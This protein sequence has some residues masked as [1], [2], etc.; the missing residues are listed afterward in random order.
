M[1]KYVFI[2]FILGVLLGY[3]TSVV[4]SGY[5][6]GW[7]VEQNGTEICSDPYVWPSLRIIECD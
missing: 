3:A 2:F 5:L 7:T 6:I 1:K 4:A